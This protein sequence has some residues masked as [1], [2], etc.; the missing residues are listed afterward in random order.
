LAPLTL[1]NPRISSASRKPNFGLG[2]K[3][4]KE[5]WAG[6]TESGFGPKSVKVIMVMGEVLYG[7][8]D[9]SFGLKSVKGREGWEITESGFGPKSV[10]VIMVM[11]EVLYGVTDFS[12]G[13]KSVNRGI[14]TESGFGR[15][16][17]RCFGGG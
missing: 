8:T 9:F 16:S 5:R 11:G 10:K 3:S 17:V 6:I 7:V 2:R 12:F 15:K 4:V 13:R 1:Q 14:V